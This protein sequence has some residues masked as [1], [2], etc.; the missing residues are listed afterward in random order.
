VAHL[1]VLAEILQL[2]LTLEQATAVQQSALQKSQR[3]PNFY[4]LTVHEGAR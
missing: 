2:P 3:I 4:L 1:A